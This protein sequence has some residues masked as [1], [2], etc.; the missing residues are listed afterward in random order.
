MRE[1]SNEVLRSFLEGKGTDDRGRTLDEILRCDDHWL[2][3]NHD[4]IQWLFPIDTPSGAN[5]NAPIVS[6]RLAKELGAMTEVAGNLRRAVCRMAAFYGFAVVNAGLQ[7]AADYRVR[8]PRWAAHPTHNDLRITRIL[9]SLT[10]FGLSKEARSFY[11]AAIAAVR[12]F[13][14]D[15]S[16]DRYWAM[17]LTA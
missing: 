12:E 14:A 5:P 9:R 2:E 13:R 16:V 3:H 7:G 10:L 17:A 1:V 8:A 4:F 15:A 11:E 6:A